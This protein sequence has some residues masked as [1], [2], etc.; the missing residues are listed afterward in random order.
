MENTEATATNFSIH[1]PKEFFEYLDALVKMR[2]ADA[3]G[4]NAK[5]VRY[6]TRRETCEKLNISMPTL[7]RYISKGI[8]PAQR[9]GNRILIDEAALTA[10][11]KKLRP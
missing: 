5:K 6:L 11:L 9:V 10:S 2:V 8:V 1:L 7:C 3:I 4:A